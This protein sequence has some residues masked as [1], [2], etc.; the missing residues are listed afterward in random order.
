LTLIK[1]TITVLARVGDLQ[2]SC[3]KKLD[4]ISAR[5]RRISIR[6]EIKAA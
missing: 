5:Y 3:F 2:S 6:K 4:T 1:F